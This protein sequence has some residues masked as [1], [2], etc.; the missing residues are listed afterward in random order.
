MKRKDPV[1]ST[2][3]IVPLT[4]Y[5]HALVDFDAVKKGEHVVEDQ[6]NN[7]AES[8]VPEVRCLFCLRN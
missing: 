3:E 4:A 8:R 6:R 1:E 2:N 5:E 7:S